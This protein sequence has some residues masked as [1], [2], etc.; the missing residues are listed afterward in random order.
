M[1]ESDDGS[2]GVRQSEEILPAKAKRS[3][4]QQGRRKHASP[5]TIAQKKKAAQIGP[6]GKVQRAHSHGLPSNLDRYD[7][8][9]DQAE[10]SS[11]AT[12]GEGVI[13]PKSKG[14]DFT[15][16]IE[17]AQSRQ[18]DLRAA[19]VPES[20]SFF[21][22]LAT[23]FMK[24]VSSIRTVR[25]KNLLFRCKDDNFVVDDDLTSSYEIPFLNLDLHA[26]AEQLSKIKLS[27]RL[28]I[29]EDLLPIDLRYDD[30]KGCSSSFQSEELEAFNMEQNLEA[31]HSHIYSPPSKDLLG[32]A[33]DHNTNIFPNPNISRASPAHGNGHE[34]TVGVNLAQQ[35]DQIE[36]EQSLKNISKSSTSK[37]GEAEAELDILLQSFKETSLSDSIQCDF[38]DQEPASKIS[39]DDSLPLH[40]KSAPNIDFFHPM[41]QHL[42]D[43]TQFSSK[44]MV[45]AS[46]DDD[47][48][49][50][51]LAETS[52]ILKLQ[53]H[54]RAP[55]P[56]PQLGSIFSNTNRSD[57]HSG[58][59]SIDVL[60]GR[61]SVLTQIGEASSK[62][63]S[64][65]IGSVALMD[66]FD[67]WMDSF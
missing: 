45:K 1:R 4:S 59:S 27:E 33:D 63:V 65:N 43:Q 6:E 56:A 46:I 50:D 55:G 37:I 10:S 36:S 52:Q 38:L 64:T 13:A 23:D 25:S 44:K 47:S 41:H 17:Q 8:G 15:Y 11:G 32:H 12:L 39:L 2:Q 5:A 60:G 28:F 14:A 42:S 49:D 7:D 57:S 61:K 40:W 20:P 51:L 53:K 19:A 3:Y 54:E 48:I 24:G 22:E 9:E 16:L 26:I 35:Y 66:D 31:P 29:E 18:N 67:S 62:G 58:S 21:D 34:T 30:S